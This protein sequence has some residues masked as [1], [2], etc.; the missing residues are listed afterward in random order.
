MNF[1][2]IYNLSLHTRHN[3]IYDVLDSTLFT[4]ISAFLH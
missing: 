1:Q 3:D 2:E 4:T